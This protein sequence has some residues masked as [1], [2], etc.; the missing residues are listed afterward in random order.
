ML[1]FIKLYCLTFYGTVG[2]KNSPVVFHA[3]A[4]SLH[5]YTVFNILFVWMKY[6]RERL[7]LP[8]L[9]ERDEVI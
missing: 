2:H 3:F 6:V 4:D 9:T 5:K 7:C 8:E 1:A